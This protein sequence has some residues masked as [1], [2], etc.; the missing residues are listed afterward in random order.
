M[1][2]LKFKVIL[3]V[4][5]DPQGTSPAD[6]EHNLHQVVNNAVQNGTLTGDTPATVEE[7]K[8]SVEQVNS[9]CNHR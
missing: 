6:L 3:N 2:T 1:K 8:F 9:S 7:Y 4:E 5:F